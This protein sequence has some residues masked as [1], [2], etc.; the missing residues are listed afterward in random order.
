MAKRDMRLGA[1]DKVAPV[2][3][4]VVE[5]LERGSQFDHSLPSKNGR[6]LTYWP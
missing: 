5:L 2:R 6:S 1:L 3:V 4:T